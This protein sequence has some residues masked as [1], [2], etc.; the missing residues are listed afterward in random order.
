MRTALL[1]GVALAGAASAQTS[2]P[3]NLTPN[4]G[5]SA[6]WGLFMDF[7]AGASAITVTDLSTAS[8]AA[9]AAPVEFEVW[10]YVGSGLGTSVT[11]GPGSDPMGWTLQGLA[12][13]FQGATASGISDLIDIPDVTVPAGQ[14]VGVCL[15]FTTA[16][17]RYFGTGTA[18][19][20]VISDGNLTLTT[21]DS[22]SAPF[23]PT[24][25]YFSSRSLCGEVIYTG[26]APAG[27]GSSYCGPAVPNTTLN[28]ASISASGSDVA[29][30]NNLTLMAS[31]MP[32][33]A[34]GFF[35]T[36]MTQGNVPQ[37]GGSQGVLCLGGSIGRYVGAGQIKNS[38]AAGMFD[39]ALD[40]TQ[41]P[42]PNGFV[43]VSAGETWNYQAWFRDSVGGVATSNFTDG[44]TITFQ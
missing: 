32:L 3:T 37:P 39:L 29:A 42:S 8:S 43:S 20:Q 30:D 6:T 21:G 23:T 15:L 9:A 2:L 27:V 36:S 17:P 7:T 31:D 22:R 12:S 14:T 34:F 5:G 44:R 25:S 19:L 1:L 26:G 41:T 28:S 38:G 33:N 40:L 13:G 35:L 16:G 11:S 18:P 24:G 10:T 4:N